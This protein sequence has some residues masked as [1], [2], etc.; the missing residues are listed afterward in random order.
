VHEV[1]A[2]TDWA[3]LTR[4]IWRGFESAV[5]YRHF[6][7]INTGWKVERWRSSDDF[8]TRCTFDAAFAAE[9]KT[10]FDGEP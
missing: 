1:Y 10:A 5:A 4:P 8:D 9:M 2:A 3:R 6:R 7:Q